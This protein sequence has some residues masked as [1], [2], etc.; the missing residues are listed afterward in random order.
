MTPEQDESLLGYVKRRSD[1]E[2]F[3][4][5]GGF[6]TM[7]GQSY[8]R[9]SIEGSAQL[10]S[11][12]GLPLAALEPILPSKQPVDPAL[13]WSFHRMHRDPVCPECIA[14][15]RPR[16]KEWRHALVTACA[17]HGCRLIEEC[18][19]CRSPLTVTGDGYARC[20]CG[21]S[22]GSAKAEQATAFEIKL[23]S[24][25]AGRTVQMAG[26]DL[27]PTEGRH[28]ARMI[29]FLS[30]NMVQARTGKEGKA[31]CPKTV[32]EAREFMSRIEPLLLDW[33]RAFDDHVVQ[34]WKAPGADGLTAAVRLGPW[35]RGFL[36]Q[37]GQLAEALLSRCL[38]VVGT[39][40]GDSYKTS[41]HQEG[42]GWVSA[43]GAGEDL[44]IR[45]ER[46][47]E[48]VRD[49]LIPGEQGRSGTG[50]LHTIIRIETVQRIRE[51]RARAA[52][53]DEVRGVLGVSRKQF[54]LL[55]EAGFF[56][57]E[58]RMPPHP[59]VDGGYDLDQ[60]QRAV[61]RVRQGALTDEAETDRAIPFRDINLRRTT[62]RKALLQILR[63]IAEQ[64]IRPVR[65]DAAGTLGDAVF[66]ETEIARLLQQHGGARSWTAGEVAIFTGWKPECV[67]GWCDRGLIQ[68][69]KARRGS[70]D[71]WQISEE[72]LAR[73]RRE[74]QVISDLAKE[75]K[76][77]SRKILAALA[78]RGITSVGSQPA[79][80]SS[81]GHL[82]RSRDL[83]QML[84]FSPG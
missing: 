42:V 43:A 9:A 11:D 71:V 29:W 41:C 49:G 47:V 27:E 5:A 26:V 40:C 55:E 77:T 31:V 15:S 81:R 79:G 24:L 83:A 44:G 70:F 28:A 60:I 3:P 19:G 34:R 33:P 38:T 18:P 82:V 58:C 45:S 74:F 61:E 51:L 76:T 69:T 36:R 50:H 52:T 23:A 80:S 30:T 67:T 72:A 16:R 1:A 78:E 75:G 57:E 7:L 21:A 37:K 63:G 22:Y 84:A 39:V 20:L 59:C 73:F 2:G 54:D 46:I 10:A 4:K 12:L 32:L 64:K 8:G 17:E 48:G 56:G 66:N 53:K 68:A 25:V 62:D 14:A 6:L 35:Y 65:F 13:D